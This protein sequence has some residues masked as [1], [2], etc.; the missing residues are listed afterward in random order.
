[1]LRRII[2]GIFPLVMGGL[3]AFIITGVRRDVS[4][5]T[6]FWWLV[7]V[8]AAGALM[9]VLMTIDSNRSWKRQMQMTRSAR[10]H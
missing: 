4:L 3:I 9:M 1:M 8:A 7:A 10:W 6:E 2:Y 5:R